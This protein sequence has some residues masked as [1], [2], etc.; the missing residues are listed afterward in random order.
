G[1]QYNSIE[2]ELTSENWAFQTLMMVFFFFTVILLL[3]VLIALINQAFTDGDGAWRQAW[4]QNRLHVIEIVEN[5]SFHIPGFREHSNYFPD[6][7]YYSVTDQEIEELKKEYPADFS[8]SDATPTTNQ[9][10][11]DELKQVREQMSTMKDEIQQRIHAALQEQMKEFKAMFA[12][13]TK[14][15][16]GPS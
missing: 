6:V 15:E 4:L 16:A 11:K 3:N 9:E 14:V 12:E 8:T 13:K 7:I 5:L 10:L 2:K 1:G